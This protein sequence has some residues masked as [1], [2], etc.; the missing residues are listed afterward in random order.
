MNDAPGVFSLIDPP[1]VI[2]KDVESSL[3]ELNIEDKEIKAR[4]MNSAF[5][6]KVIN[7]NR[8]NIVKRL[9]YVLKM[10]SDQLQLLLI[11]LRKK[12]ENLEEIKT[13]IK[14]DLINDELYRDWT[15]LYYF[16]KYVP[17]KTE[18]YKNNENRKEKDIPF[19]E[20]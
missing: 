14:H 11:N 10:R 16:S 9:I 7:E 12:R 15:M 8:E 5:Y 20:L 17:K 13:M 2:P 1:E 3:E 18:K 4:V 19:P 6:Y